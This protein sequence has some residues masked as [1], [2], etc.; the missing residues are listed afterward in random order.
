MDC[1]KLKQINKHRFFHVPL[2]IFYLQKRVKCSHCRALFKRGAILLNKS[3]KMRTMQV[4][5]LYQAANI[6]KHTGIKVNYQ[7]LCG[8]A[9]CMCDDD[10]EMV[11]LVVL[12]QMLFV[13]LEKSKWR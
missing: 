4:F 11:D 10:A 12:F 7:T 8:L 2:H 3:W 6:V 1:V 9:M 5:L 13:F